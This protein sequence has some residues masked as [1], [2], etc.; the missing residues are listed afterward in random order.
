MCPEKLKVGLSSAVISTSY[1]IEP[2]ANVHAGGYAELRCERINLPN[3][4]RVS[5]KKE[6]GVK[7]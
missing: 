7:S 5:E 3:K 6:L 1:K 2:P 4:I